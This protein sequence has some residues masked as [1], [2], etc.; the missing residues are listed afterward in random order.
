MPQCHRSMI[1]SMAVLRSDVCCMPGVLAVVMHQH[2]VC[3]IPPAQESADR[4]A[5]FRPSVLQQYSGCKV[6][7]GRLGAGS[8]RV[9]IRLDGVVWLKMS[10]GGCPCQLFVVLLLQFS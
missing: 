10:D 2:T 8:R 1:K 9:T 7:L 4:K 6:C 3:D 5:C